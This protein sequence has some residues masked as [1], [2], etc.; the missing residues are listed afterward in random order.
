M[1][2]RILSAVI[3]VAVGVLLLILAWPQL[4]DLE[5]A[6]IIAQVVSLRSVSVAAGAIGALLLLVLSLAFRR[7]RR[8]FGTLA[9]LFVVFSLISAV[10][11][12]SRGFGNPAPDDA[13]TDVTVLAWNT[14]GDAPGAAAI[15]DLAVANQADVIA[16]PETTKDMGVEVANLMRAAGRPMWVHTTAF[17]DELKAQSTTLLISPDLGTYTV[18]KDIGDTR[19]LPTVVATPDDGSGPT[20]ASV[21]PV[22]PIPQQMRNWRADLQWLAGLCATGD[23]SVILAGDFNATIDHLTGLGVDGATLGACTDAAAATGN[24]AVGT[25]PTMFPALVGAPIDHVMATADW[26]ATGVRVIDTHDDFGS[27]HRPLVVKLQQAG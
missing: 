15:A 13:P 5:Q 8:F 1:F 19:V 16:L 11:L 3:T 17:D 9:T 23:G 26:V 10:V 18:R 14:L 22:S 21:H 7:T 4:F 2:A 27:D 6:P 20:I 12:A 24:G 25:W